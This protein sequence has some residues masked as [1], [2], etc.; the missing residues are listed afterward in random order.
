MS[1][2]M[3]AQNKVYKQTKSLPILNKKNCIFYTHKKKK[4]L[5]EIT[6]FE[7]KTNW[8]YFSLILNLDSFS[9]NTI[10]HAVV[11]G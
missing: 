3:N 7:R 10:G 5:T 8:K 6:F 9:S 4:K 11:Q 2:K 1:R